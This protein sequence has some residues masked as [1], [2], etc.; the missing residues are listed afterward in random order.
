MSVADATAALKLQQSSTTKS[1][2]LPAGSSE[3]SITQSTAEDGTDD[4]GVKVLGR[5]FK[6]L[7]TWVSSLV[8]GAKTQDKPENN[9]KGKDSK[10]AK[11]DDTI[12]PTEEW[13][14][15]HILRGK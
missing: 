15:T 13:L 2:G 12:F 3:I 8:E 14:P 7:A 10:E 1:A 6:K 5:P 11:V 9:K 4:I